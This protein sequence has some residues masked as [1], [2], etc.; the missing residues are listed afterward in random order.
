MPC[1]R[2]CHMPQRNC[3]A[4]HNRE[5]P[6]LCT[7]S[8]LRILFNF[9]E[10]DDTGRIDGDVF[11][12]FADWVPLSLAEGV[13]CQGP[14]SW[15]RFCQLVGELHIGTLATA[16]VQG[17]LALLWRW[18]DPRGSGRL[19]APQRRAFLWRLGLRDAEWAEAEWEGEWAE[20]ESEGDEATA[21]G[22]AFDE[23]WAVLERA[24]AQ[25][26]TDI[27]MAAGVVM[28]LQHRP[29]SV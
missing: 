20:V 19:E 24:P 3:P 5:Q 18:A 2:P 29:L 10:P 15:P 28:R 21:S 16:D 25:H 27:F 13:A 17:G 1:R 14:L 6:P 12:K 26:M 4:P 8:G 7:A 9:F 11:T 23:F 22:M